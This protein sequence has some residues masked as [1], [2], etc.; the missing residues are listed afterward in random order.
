VD[1]NHVIEG[2]LGN[3]AT[4]IEETGAV[5]AISPLPKMRVDAVPLTHVLQNLISNALKYRGD[6]PPRIAIDVVRA[7]SFWRFSVK[8]NGIG[9]PEEFRTQIFGIF[10]RLHDRKTYP[11]TGIGLAICQKIV[12]RHGGRIWVES[13][14]DRGSEFFFTWPAE[15]PR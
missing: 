2:V 13:A 5:L 8:D 9:I 12:E 14:P 1:V 7:G 6:K 10:K 11:G 4:T 3:L 15:Q